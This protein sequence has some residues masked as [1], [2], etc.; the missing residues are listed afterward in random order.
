MATMPVSL[1]LKVAAAIVL[2]LDRLA[3]LEESGDG[4]VARACRQ[5]VALR[6]RWSHQQPALLLVGRVH[7]GNIDA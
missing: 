2:L 3:V 4:F 5:H 7:V 6:L 1:L